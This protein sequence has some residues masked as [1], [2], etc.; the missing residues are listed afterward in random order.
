MEVAAGVAVVAE[1]NQTAVAPIRLVGVVHASSASMSLVERS[2]PLV[3]NALVQLV[4]IDVDYAVDWVVFDG[5]KLGD[6]G[7][8]LNRKQHWRDA[9]GWNPNQS[10]LV[11]QRSC[12]PFSVVPKVAEL[13]VSNI[14]GDVIGVVV[15]AL[16]GDVVLL[17]ESF[18]ADAVSK[19]FPTDPTRPS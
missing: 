19:T 16:A 11:Q 3:D 15:A 4:V 14:A 8:V 10:D 13:E 7:S 5:E 6:Q 17:Q 9:V 1:G 18:F 2:R 12:Q